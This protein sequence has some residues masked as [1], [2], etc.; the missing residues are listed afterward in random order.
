MRRLMLVLS[1]TLILFTSLPIPKQQPVHSQ[2]PSQDPNQIYP[3]QI[4]EPL[5]PPELV[6]IPPPE[7][8]PE[9]E[10]PEIPFKIHLEPQIFI[11]NKPISLSLELSDN[12]KTQV[13]GKTLKIE[14]D[15]LLTPIDENYQEILQ[16]NGSLELPLSADLQPLTFSIDASRVE[17]GKDIALSVSILDSENILFT[18]SLTIPT[19][20]HTIA[21]TNAS[22]LERLGFPL[23]IQTQDETI[24]RDFLF[25]SGSLRS[26]SMPGYSLSLRPIEILAVNKETGHNEIS[27]DQPLHITLGYFENEFTPEEENNLQVFYYNEYYNDWFPIET[28]VDPDNNQVSFQTKHLTVFDIKATDW[29]SYIQPITQ[30]YEVSAF[31]GALTYNY[32]INT[33]EGPAGLKPYLSLN[34]NSQAIDQSVAFTQPSWVGMGWSLE[35]GSI[36]RDMHGTNDTDD[37]DSFFLNFNGVSN[38]LLPIAREG[39]LIK[40]RSQENP[41]EKVTW[42]TE[43]DTW[44]IS[45]S[46]GLSYVFGGEGAIARIKENS[47]CATS[48]GQLNLTW[49]WGLTTVADRFGNTINYTYIPEIK[50]LSDTDDPNVDVTCYNHISLIPEKITYG[51]FEIAFETTARNDF[52]SSWQ[53]KDS[54]VLFS[55]FRLGHIDLKVNNQIVKSYLLKYASNSEKNN[56]IY[57]GFKWFNEALTSTLIS[58]QEVKTSEENP[59][60][61]YEPLTFS[62]SV[63]KM[64]LDKVTNGYGGEIDFSYKALYQADD[65]NKDLRT[66]RWCF[67]SSGCPSNNEGQVVTYCIPSNYWTGGWQGENTLIECTGTNDGNMILHH[68][69][70]I[71]SVGYINFPESM[72]KPGGKYIFYGRARRLSE[73]SES[74][75][76]EFGITTGTPIPDSPE[77]TK[78]VP[79][80]FM[81]TPV[82]DWFEGQD[83]IIIPANYNFNK[84][85]VFLRNSGILIKDLQIQQFITRYVITQRVETDTLTGKSASWTY[86]Y[87]DEGFMM[88]TGKGSHPYIKTNLE[89]RGFHTVT[90]TQRESTRQDSLVTVQ[91]FH[92]D[93]LLKGRMSSEVV[94]DHQGRCYS[95]T[96][97]TYEATTIYPYTELIG[98]NTYT[99]LD[100]NWIKT[101]EVEEQSFDGVDFALITSSPFISQ[102]EVFTFSPPEVYKLNLN[103]NPL[104]TRERFFNGIDWTDNLETFYQFESMLEPVFTGRSFLLNKDLKSIK[105]NAI[106]H[107]GNTGELLAETLFF[108]N[109]NRTLSSQKVWATGSGATSGY[110]QTSF[111]YQTNGN[112][113]KK[114]QWQGFAGIS[115]DP[116]GAQL[117]TSYAYDTVFPSQVSEQVISSP[118]DNQTFSTT[119]LF[120]TYLGLP[121][122]ISHPNGAIESAV[123]D[124]LGRM[125]RVCAPGDASDYIACKTGTSFTID[126]EYALKASPPRITIIRQHLANVQLNYTGFGNLS[127][128]TLLNA[129]IFD[130]PVNWVE[131]SIV[132][133]GLGR[134]VQET[135]AGFTSK[136]N[137]DSLGRVVSIS[138]VEGS[139][140]VPEASYTYQL[141]D[142]GSGERNWKKTTTDANG[143][144]T[145]EYTDAQGLV[146]KVEPPINTGPSVIFSYDAIGRLLKT[147]YG[148]A[149]SEITYN[150]AGN[151]T[152]MIDADMGE[153]QY[154]YNADGSLR[155]QIDANQNKTCLEYDP[156][157]RLISKSFGD[158]ATYCD[159]LNQN[160]TIIYNYDELGMTGYRTSMTDPS[161]S[162]QWVYDAR[163]R[164]VREEK[165]ILR[166]TF[167]TE[168]AYNSA[169]QL[170]QMIYPT[171]ERVGYTYLPQGNIESVGEYQ[172][173]IMTDQHNRLEAAFFNANDYFVAHSLFSYDDWLTGGGNLI[174]MSI[175]GNAGQSNALDL[176]YGYDLVG[177]ITKI[178]DHL[179]QGQEQSFSYD[180][181][182]RLTTAL[183]N[184][185][186][187]GQYSQNYTYDPS[188]GSLSSRSDVGNYVYS[189]YNSH[190]VTTAGPNIY[191][192]DFNGNMIARVTPDGVWEY[193]YDAE[194][195]LTEIKKDGEFVNKYLYDGDGN[196]VAR[197]DKD[198]DGT[199]YVG[200]YF[201]TRYYNNTIDP[202]PPITEGD[203]PVD[204]QPGTEPTPTPVKPVG[205][206]SYYYA[207]G[208]RIAM[209]IG[210]EPYL[211]FG[212]HLGSTS[213]VMDASGEVVEKGY[214]LPWGGTRG[215]E[216]ITSAVNVL[217]SMYAMEYSWSSNRYTFSPKPRETRQHPSRLPFDRT[218][219]GGQGNP[220][221]GVRKS[222]HL[223]DPA[224]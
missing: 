68:N 8:Q 35:T 169:D 97:F 53:H 100:I 7:V 158:A 166:R 98:L 120:S 165:T 224:I 69:G 176:E 13:N 66:I 147:N 219:R 183:T 148:G 204:S 123:Y 38:R 21:N 15:S 174:R 96:L 182:N 51:A 20:A 36:T 12:Q 57:P 172:S 149:E 77:E 192:Y 138:R 81:S 91:T 117:T 215:D 39:D 211:L 1:I 43:N 30:S 186:G 144:S 116:E 134:A 29:Q 71:D 108:Y 31:T 212:D 142:V 196:R 19:D 140:S 205:D 151:K 99:D 121:I 41:D 64:H 104:S 184:Q 49:Q 24:N 130:Q 180:A 17:P 146:V 88:N 102:Q 26:Q 61:G 3:N 59:V 194:N 95:R 62:Y 214:Y 135:N 65:I 14:V 16:N 179:N 45:S 170:I 119:T 72:L 160:P 75:V 76:T 137:Y 82:G 28:T 50:G 175:W 129:E 156:F 47:G 173:G 114:T 199:I 213:V 40:F 105:V 111:S 70:S 139:A 127:S 27:F 110:Q 152:S 185:L 60:E 223:S 107:N 18:Q 52:R 9:P 143:N 150:A 32:P 46:N 103:G 79:S 209:R 55:R 177:N 181:L 122:Q 85:L 136:T 189:P 217:K 131:K 25:Y 126:I 109:P 125:I 178:T 168:W 2:E 74:P 58:V 188:T 67:G 133:D 195:H 54:K 90:I 124:G 4:S 112:L 153:W 145:S 6:D 84:V 80:D 22:S 89:Y 197:I 171:G 73:E 92:Q 208:Q 157:G 198:Y 87:P 118:G 167:I 161:G 141:V 222:T 23:L 42:D 37:D 163:G 34:Y 154:F 155:A 63:D 216:T 203:N 113:S 159:T 132:Y 191:A 207:G 106:T 162:T 33:F 200:N 86:T 94:M 220:W 93:D 44:E 187:E 221:P 193:Q 83:Y 56:V 101:T 218:L 206:V 11:E 190:A 202:P 210:N 201:E 164:V 10:P 128:R 48:S 115:S 78:S 5:P